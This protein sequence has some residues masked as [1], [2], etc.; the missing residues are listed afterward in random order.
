MPNRKPNPKP[1]DPAQSHRFKELA[2]ELE[3]DD[4]EK[5]LR[6]S[7]KRLGEH[8]PERRRKLGKKANK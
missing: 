8:A 3:A 1:D 2:K 4:G 5:D 6:E 7:V